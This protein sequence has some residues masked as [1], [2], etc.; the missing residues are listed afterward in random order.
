MHDLVSADDLLRVAFPKLD[1]AQIAVL[2]RAG[3]RRQCAGGDFLFRTGD[4]DLSLYVILAGEVKIFGLH[5]CEE[6]SVVVS[7]PRDFVGE[8]S[9]LVGEAAVINAPCQGTVELIEVRHHVLRR[10]LAGV[11]FVSEP[12][13]R[14]FL[15]RRARLEAGV[16][17][18]I[19]LQ[20][21]G[22]ADSHAAFYL[23]DFFTKNHLPHRFTDADG[24]E[25]LALARRLALTSS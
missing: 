12:I 7:G 11:T 4:V 20:V 25:G 10:V 2:D 8:V 15:A 22:A 1:D 9:M 6:A 5:D 23:H 24:E 3:T 13:V 16:H 18:F 21:L 14:A 19:G 17:S